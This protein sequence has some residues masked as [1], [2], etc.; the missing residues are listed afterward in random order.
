MFIVMI[1]QRFIGEHDR[2]L[3]IGGIIV[4]AI[5]RNVNLILLSNYLPIILI[6][7]WLHLHVYIDMGIIYLA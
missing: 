3:S 1:N 6:G 2:F 4:H 7:K 5:F